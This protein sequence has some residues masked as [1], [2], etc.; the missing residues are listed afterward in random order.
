[1]FIENQYYH[2]Y[3]QGNNGRKLFFTD[4]DYDLF[5][6]K[7]M[8]YI[9]PFAS[10]HAYCLMPNHYHIFIKVNTASIKRDIF[11]NEVEKLQKKYL[12]TNQVSGRISQIRINPNYPTD[13][14]LS[15][16]IAII[17]RS[18]TRAINHKK[19]WSG[20]MFRC[21][22]KIN[23]GFKDEFLGVNEIEFYNDMNFIGICINYIHY[24]PVKDF[25]CKNPEDWEYSSAKF[26][27]DNNCL[28]NGAI[29]HLLEITI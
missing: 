24:N 5:R 11:I 17:Q 9:I 10:L 1:M 29:N 21:N 23:D 16:S 22:F 25:L 3:N 13:I 18:Y 28:T 4:A 20:S 15:D 19:N 26:Y 6:Y 14:T 27:K 7:F 12:G 8:T 2:I